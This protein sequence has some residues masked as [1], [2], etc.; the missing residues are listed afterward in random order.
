MTKTQSLDECVTRN[1]EK[2]FSDLE[3]DTPRSVYDM[4]ITAVERPMPDLAPVTT[5][6]RPLIPRSICFVP[7]A[8]MS[9]QT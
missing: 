2:Y 3:G 5:A 4:V 9:S 7:L 8:S 6:T 1:L